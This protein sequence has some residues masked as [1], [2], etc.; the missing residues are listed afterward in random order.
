M[1][2]L[3]ISAVRSRWGAL[4]SERASWDEQWRD[5]SE[6]LLPRAS[7]FLS[8]D[9][10]KG[11]R[12]HRRILDNTAT[13]ALRVGAAG[14][15]SGLTSPARPWMRLSTHDED[16]SK[17]PA[18]ELWLSQTTRRMLDVFARSNTYRALHTGY[19]EL[20]A[21]G[22]MSNIV[23]SDDR[24]TIH[25]Y[26]LTV[27]E[28]CLATNW[29]GEV[30][31]LYREFEKTVG[32]IVA[33][34]G[35]ENCSP[36]VQN[37]WD[38]GNLHVWIGLVH[39]IEPRTD[40][41]SNMRDQ[42]NMAWKSVYFEAGGAK[43]K[44][45]RE[46]GFRNFPALAARWSTSGGDVYGSGPGMDCLGDIRQLQHQQ[47][48]KAQSIDYMNN[49]P[50]QVP[51]SAKGR[52]IDTLPGGVTFVD[53]V[54][55]GGGI[56]TL[57]DARIDLSHLLADMQDVRTR[58][59][60]T[61]NTDLFLMMANSTNTNMTATEVAERHEEKM[62]MLGPVVERLHSEML[63]PL[64]DVTF[65]NMLTTGQIPKPPPELQGVD[66]NVNYVS[67]LAQAQRA[68]ATNG[69]DRFVG[70]LGRIAQLK[71]DLLDKFDSDTWADRYSD[72][73]GV[74]PELIVPSGKVALIRDQRAKAQAQAQ[75]AAQMEQLASTAQ[76]MGTVQTDTGNAGA[77]VLRAFQGYT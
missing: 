29:R 24:S 42:K 52:E 71:P 53:Q 68:V 56:K 36:S 76:K 63:D 17:Y 31:T 74:D 47:L 55:A 27:G 30:V 57:F 46:G 20:Q 16:L 3:D 11:D 39:A 41:D 9:R 49:P 77:D 23:L 22:T 19:E 54:A 72:M 73:L 10:N 14:M 5:I 66:L 25:N 40:R 60:Q 45:L 13:R 64:I 34:F 50:L 61:F 21:F 7:R 15:M 32:E 62:L 58:I 70:N 26:P 33:E 28:Y 59:N 44:V 4:K 18:V 1:G 65:E 38:R 51:S 67:V 35:R 6:V 8:S 37:A 43:D 48:R 69:V 2:S 75:Q 12:K